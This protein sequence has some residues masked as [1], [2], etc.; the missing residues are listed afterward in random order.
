MRSG[1]GRNLEFH[2]VEGFAFGLDCKVICPLPELVWLYSLYHFM[3]CG[4][5]SCKSTGCFLNKCEDISSICQLFYRL[6][7][8]FSILKKMTESQYNVDW[9]HEH[10]YMVLRSWHHQDRFDYFT[11]Y[12]HFLSVLFTEMK[13]LML[14]ER[15]LHSTMKTILMKI[16]IYIYIIILYIN[17]ILIIHIIKFIFVCRSKSSY[18]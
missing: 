1:F 13:D 3:I 2:F 14:Y 17:N 5:T 8:C 4:C 16:Y 15:P 18:I 11:T 7:F 10:W 9:C 12:V 6:H